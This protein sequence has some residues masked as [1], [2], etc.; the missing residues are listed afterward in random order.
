MHYVRTWT[1]DLV[2]E[3]MIDSLRWAADTAGHVGPRGYA[4]SAALSGYRATLEDHLRE[5]WGLPEE[6]LPDEPRV[7]DVANG[8]F[9]LAEL[10]TNTEGW[11]APD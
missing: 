4:R 6:L 5:G 7:A 3:V 8:I 11:L 2:A 10:L 1:P 9:T